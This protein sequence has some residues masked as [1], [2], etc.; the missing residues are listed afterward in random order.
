MTNRTV[1]PALLVATLLA[2][3]DSGKMPAPTE[4][5]VSFDE[6][7]HDNRGSGSQFKRIGNAR[8]VRDPENPTNVV[9]KVT[10]TPSFAA[11]GIKRELKRVQLWQ[12]DH[13]LNFHRAFDAPHTCGGGSP[14]I[15]MLIDANGDGR[16]QQAP[17]GPDFVAHGHVRP[18]HAGC[19]MSEP[20]PN[21]G[22]PAPSTLLWRFEDLTDE[23]ARWEITPGSVATGIGLPAFPYALWDV[24]E[25]AI[26]L[27]FPNH[28]VLDGRLIEDFSPTPGVA[29]YDLITIFDLTFGT[30]GQTQ[31]G[32]R[33]GDDHDDDGDDD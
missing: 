29:Y 20:T 31:L 21:D 1:V 7:R 4:N 28:Q 23:Q 8:S 32:G 18:P 19:E 14:R 2:C 30:R 5:S 17:A 11:T 9:L 33:D 12:L 3:D 10:S 13:Q 24:F 27:A 25:A 15:Q 22:G 16:F 6:D 26:H